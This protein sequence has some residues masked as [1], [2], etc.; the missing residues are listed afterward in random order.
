[1]PGLIEISRLV[2]IMTARM[3]ER[4]DRDSLLNVMCK[5]RLTTVCKKISVVP[6]AT[7]EM[8]MSWLQQYYVPHCPSAVVYMTY[9]TFRKLSLIPPSGRWLSLYRQIFISFS[10]L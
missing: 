6:I 4:A 10:L 2:S 3:K 8:Q 5:E 1:M 7:V 9:M